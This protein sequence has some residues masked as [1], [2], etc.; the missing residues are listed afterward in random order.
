MLLLGTLFRDV[1]LEK[2]EEIEQEKW[3]I[4]VT[5]N[6][7]LNV[8]TFAQAQKSLREFSAKHIFNLFFHFE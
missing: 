2:G 3:Y 1:D 4:V 6:F 7:L 5:I 8:V